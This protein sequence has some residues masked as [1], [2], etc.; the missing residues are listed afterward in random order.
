MKKNEV[1][2]DHM[3]KAIFVTA[4]FIKKAGVWGTEEYHCFKAMRNENPEYTIERRSVSGS[5]KVYKGLSI[6]RMREYIAFKEGA[7]SETMETF[8]YVC[9]EAKVRGHAYPRVKSWFVAKYPNYASDPDWSSN[10][11]TCAAA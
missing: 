9:A 8:K 6:T 4:D 2:V 10:E 11:E 1:F 5:K 7:E 3:N